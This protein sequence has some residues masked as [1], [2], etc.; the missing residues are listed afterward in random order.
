MRKGIN[1]SSKQFIVLLF[2]TVVLVFFTLFYIW[3]RLDV[4]KASYKLHELQVRKKYLEE[5][6]KKLEVRKERL[7]NL[8][9]VEEIAKNRLKMKKVSPEDIFIV[10]IKRDEK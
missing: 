2:I 1:N 6:I 7:L 4:T 9:R 5:K 8:R 10:V 3:H